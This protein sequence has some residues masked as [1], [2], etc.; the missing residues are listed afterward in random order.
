M[1]FFGG[2]TVCYLG[3]PYRLE[4]ADDPCESRVEGDRLIIA[5]RAGTSARTR[6]L[7][8]CTRE[9]ERIIGELVP[10]WSKALDVRPRSATVRYAR[11]R[12]GSC[13]ARGDLY[14]NARISMLSPQVAEYLAV[15]ELCHIKV[16]DHSRRF[17][18][19]VRAA[20]PDAIERRAQLRAEEARCAM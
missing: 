3:E 9:T 19:E 10:R 4:L 11:T 7:W 13:T 6:L 8:W 14:F 16:M 12:W 18:D 5:P 20:L 1:E 15:H 2:E 17:W